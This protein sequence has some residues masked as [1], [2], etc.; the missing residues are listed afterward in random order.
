MVH[1]AGAELV[2]TTSSAHISGCAV[3]SALACSALSPGAVSSSEAWSPVTLIMLSISA[4]I[5]L[6]PASSIPREDGP[7]RSIHHIQLSCQQDILPESSA[8]YSIH[9][10]YRMPLQ[11]QH[12]WHVRG[13]TWAVL[14]KVRSSMKAVLATARGWLRAWGLISASLPSSLSPSKSTLT[15]D[16][17]GSS[18]AGEAP[19]LW[20]ATRCA[21]RSPSPCNNQAFVLTSI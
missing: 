7:C 2:C 10:L 17:N 5:P 13:S 14:S 19:M 3:A 8:R 11:S 9:C 6:S 20:K 16:V 1:N 18:C 12:G 4:N 21:A 15:S